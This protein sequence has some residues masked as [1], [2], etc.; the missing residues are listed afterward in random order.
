[1]KG[2][3]AV[4]IAGLEYDKYRKVNGKWLMSE[5]RLKLFILSPYEKGWGKVRIMK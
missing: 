4:W 1:L 5:M 3:G 2:A